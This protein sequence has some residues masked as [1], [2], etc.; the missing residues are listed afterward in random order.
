MEFDRGVMCVSVDP[1]VFAVNNK[2][3]MRF[4]GSW[5]WSK[6][7]SEFDCRLTTRNPVTEKLQ[8]LRV[9]E[10]QDGFLNITIKVLPD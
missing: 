4:A 3:L 8:T 9:I 7:P 10:I 6:Q 5:F 2:I 1:S